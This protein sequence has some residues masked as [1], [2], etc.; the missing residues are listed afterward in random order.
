MRTK[1]YIQL[2]VLMIMLTACSKSDDSNGQTT[3][4]TPIEKTVTYNADVSK[5][6]T[7]YCTTCHAG[8]AASAG[9]DLTTYSNTKNAA[10]NGNLVSRM[11]N[12]NNPMPPSGILSAETRQLID[13]WVKD[14]FPEK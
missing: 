14:G 7:N 5:I 8:S 9:L 1:S 10:K 2:L 13:K 6:M 12:T 4:E 11:N 3:T